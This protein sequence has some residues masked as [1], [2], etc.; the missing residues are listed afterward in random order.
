MKTFFRLTVL[1]IVVTM[2]ACFFTACEK[3][4]YEKETV[5]SFVSELQKS[6]LNVKSAQEAKISELEAEYKADIVELESK[7]SELQAL[8]DALTEEYTEQIA[9]LKASDQATDDQL[10][11]LKT[12]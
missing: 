8:I 3:P 10:E 1:L 12:S 5:D 6:I 7:N 2:C 9:S 11:N 4:Y